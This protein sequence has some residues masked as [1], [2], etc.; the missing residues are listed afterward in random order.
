MPRIRNYGSVSG[1]TADAVTEV[2]T[3]VLAQGRVNTVFELTG[4][5]FGFAYSAVLASSAEIFANLV[6]KQT[7][8]QPARTSQTPQPIATGLRGHS[9]LRPQAMIDTWMFAWAQVTGAGAGAPLAGNSEWVS[10]SLLVPHIEFD[11]AIGS[12]GQTRV[13]D[14]WCVI[15]YEPREVSAPNWLRY[16]AAAGLDPGDLEESNIQSS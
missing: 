13:W 7:N 16:L 6:L 9:D 15:E 1:S 14:A 10:T 4:Y 8:E 12:Q 5:R 11:A 2:G 3:L